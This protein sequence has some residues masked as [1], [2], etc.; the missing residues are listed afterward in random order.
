MMVAMEVTH[1]RAEMLALL[2]LDELSRGMRAFCI[3]AQQ[4]RYAIVH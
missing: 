3:P 2:V 4:H 1:V